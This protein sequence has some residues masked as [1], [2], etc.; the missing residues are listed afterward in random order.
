MTNKKKNLKKKHS[1]T[2]SMVK[3]KKIDNFEDDFVSKEVPDISII[4][5]ETMSEN[6]EFSNTEQFVNL[7]DFQ[8]PPKS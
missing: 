4:M 6:E 1:R 8:Q 5:I 2:L 7:Y 3:Q